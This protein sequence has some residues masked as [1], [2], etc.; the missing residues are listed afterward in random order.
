MSWWKELLKMVGSA[1]LDVSAGA[2]KEK[3]KGD[4]PATGKNSKTRI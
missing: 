3:L 1:V 2:A 4:P